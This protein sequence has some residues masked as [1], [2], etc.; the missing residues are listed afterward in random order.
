MPWFRFTGD[1]KFE[2]HFSNGKVE[3]TLSILSD[4]DEAGCW[5]WAARKMDGTPHPAEVILWREGNVMAIREVLSHD[6]FPV[7]AGTPAE[8]IMRAAC[9]I[10]RAE[11]LPE[12]QGERAA[13]LRTVQR[14]FSYSE[15]GQKCMKSE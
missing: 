12:E 6:G 14:R 3:F 9:R 7:E 10:R 2:L 1:V 15:R 11:V 13:Y 8:K 5:A 4:G